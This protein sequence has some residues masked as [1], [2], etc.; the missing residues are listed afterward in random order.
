M[1]KLTSKLLDK[2]ILFERKQKNSKEIL[3]ILLV[4]YL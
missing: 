3:W 1:E 2:N 4:A